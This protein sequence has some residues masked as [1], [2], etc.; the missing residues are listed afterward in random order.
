VGSK[1]LAKIK[2]LRRADETSQSVRTARGGAALYPAEG[3]VS[4]PTTNHP[5]PCFKNAVFLSEFLRNPAKKQPI[6][7]QHLPNVPVTSTLSVDAGER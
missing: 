5:S 6:A 2:D 7:A 4:D 1:I 3:Q